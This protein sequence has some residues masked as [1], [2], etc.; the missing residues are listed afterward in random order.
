MSNLIT[1]E[2]EVGRGEISGRDTGRSS[3]PARLE[4][5][6]MLSRQRDGGGYG[7]HDFETTYNLCEDITA[8]ARASKPI[9]HHDRKM[10]TD[11]DPVFEL[12]K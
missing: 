9:G 3:G 11:P 7:E 12:W 5:K 6:K 8:S 10:A 1:G 2:K 4:L